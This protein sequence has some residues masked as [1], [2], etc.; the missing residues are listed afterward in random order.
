MFRE[1]HIR[2]MPSAGMT[3]LPVCK[4]HRDNGVEGVEAVPGWSARLHAPHC[5]DTARQLRTTKSP[6]PSHLSSTGTGPGNSHTNTG[7]PERINDASPIGRGFPARQLGAGNRTVCG[8]FGLRIDV[9]V[10][11]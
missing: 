3:F 1:T 6:K 5:P 10:V 7:S 4:C 11:L 9:S 8:R 2:P